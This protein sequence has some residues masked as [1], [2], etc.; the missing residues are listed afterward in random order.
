MLVMLLIVDMFLVVVVG[1]YVVI[2][3][4]Y[5]SKVDVDVVIVYL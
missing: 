2:F 5:G 4:V 1:N 3:G